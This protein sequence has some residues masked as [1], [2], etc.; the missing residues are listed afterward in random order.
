MNDT[1]IRNIYIL[2]ILALIGWGCVAAVPAIET[3][4]TYTFGKS[5]KAAVQSLQPI[6]F[7]EEQAIGGS[8][9]IQ[10]FNK[11]G[12]MYDNPELQR[13]IAT[14]GQAVADVSDR[15]NIDY[16]FAIVNDEQPNAF[17][18]PGGYVFVS[19]GLIRLLE[20][21]AQLA[22]VLGHEI[23]HISQKHA[24]KALERN[25]KIAGFGALSVSMMGADPAVFDKVLEQ[26]AEILFTHGLDKGLEYE[27]DKFGTDFAARVGYRE[28][29]LKDFLETLEKSLPNSESALLS[30]HPSASDRLAQLSQQMGN[31][32]SI[33]DSP[34][35]AEQFQEAVKGKI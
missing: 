22:G 1:G 6:G 27:A 17:A 31:F 7:E 11:F 8:L 10:V 29:G 20:N 15:P 23:A 2:L 14:V 28:S 5:G 13:Y 19:I 25:K 34:L 32:S 9:A 26:A 18:T 12:G 24:L 16:Y 21:E 3:Y 33:G 4:Q 30:T 35:L